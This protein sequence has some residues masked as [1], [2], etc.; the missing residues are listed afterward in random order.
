[1]STNLISQA[2]D[3]NSHGI[4]NDLLPTINSV[5]VVIFLP[6]LQ[7]VVNP[8]LRRIKLPFPPVSRMTVGFVVEAMAMAYVAGIQKLIYSRGPCFSRPRHCEASQNGLTPN[9]VHVLIQIP[10]YILEGVG[11]TF[12]NPA[13]YEYAYTMAPV[14]MKTVIQAAFQLS[15]AGGSLLALALTPTYKDPD[16]LVMYASLAGCMFLTACV[17]HTIFRKY[18]KKRQS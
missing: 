9:D 2:A 1:M 17:F 3:M 7:H 10:V 18:N 8:F 5:T 13:G 6:F 12:S 16:V 4:P 11:E 14:S 15:S